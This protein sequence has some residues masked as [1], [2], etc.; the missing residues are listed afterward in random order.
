MKV[1]GLVLVVL[2][3]MALAFQGFSFVA[4]DRVA[5][6]RPVQ[7]SVGRGEK[8]WLPPVMGGIS[9]VG[10]LILLATGTDRRLA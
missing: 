1:M 7:M 5:E 8:E 6:V 4:G 2:G 3:A 10:G 9:V